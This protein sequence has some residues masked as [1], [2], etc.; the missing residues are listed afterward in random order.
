MS[1][2]VGIYIRGNEAFFSY[3]EGGKIQQGKTALPAYA[4]ED[5]FF[6][7][8]KAFRDAFAAIG[9]YIKEKELITD[10]EYIL[11]IPD[12]FGV[13]EKTRVW[14]YAGNCGVPIVRYITRTMALGLAVAFFSGFTGNFMAAFDNGT[15][16]MIGEYEWGDDV[17]EKTATYLFSGWRGAETESLECDEYDR[18]YMF[19]NSDAEDVFFAG[20]AQAQRELE[21]RLLLSVAKG[22]KRTVHAY[23]E[24]NALAGLAVYCA[25]LSG[26]SELAGRKTDILVLD[27]HAPYTMCVSWKDEMFDMLYGDTTIPTL[28]RKDLRSDTPGTD[29]ILRVYEKR[30]E[31][32]VLQGVIIPPEIEQ[33]K[34][35]AEKDLSVKVDVGINGICM[36]SILGGGT[37]LCP[38]RPVEAAHGAGRNPEHGEERLSL[39]TSLLP[40]IQNLSYGAQYGGDSNPYAKGM[41]NIFEQT[42]S[43][44]KKQGI[45]LIDSTGVPFDVRYHYAV[46]HITDPSKPRSTVVKIV[47]TGC[48]DRGTV[49]QP[50]YVV[51]A[52]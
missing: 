52:N 26:V 17:L 25:K 16:L 33:A 49:I 28:K 18:Q 44:L 20:S 6:S 46:S 2:I 39:L 40:V 45:E 19:R 11:C 14:Q 41:A 50:A 24:W 7:D 23:S 31:R 36:F 12:S 51:V 13:G 37:E 8:Q 43:I 27:I 35:Q 9:H 29:N 48:M 22:R 38:G 21:A 5:T 4:G 10:P 3:P 34:L 30:G 42:R 47:Q 1:V 15:D 32:Y